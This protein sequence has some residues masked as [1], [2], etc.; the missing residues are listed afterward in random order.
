MQKW[1]KHTAGRSRK[2]HLSF[3]TYSLLLANFW[4]HLELFSDN[5]EEC[6]ILCLFILR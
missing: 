2:L 4:E 1:F 5:E 6:E 3:A